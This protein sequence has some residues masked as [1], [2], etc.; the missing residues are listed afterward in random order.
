MT[1]VFAQKTFPLWDAPVDFCFTLRGKRLF[2]SHKTWRGMLAGVA[3]ATATYLVQR[4]LLV[5]NAAVRD[6]SAFDYS[7]HSIVLGAWIGL[8]GLT[9]DLIKS[10]VKRQLDI[11]PGRPWIPFDQADWLIETVSVSC[12]VVQ[13]PFAFSLTVLVVGIALHI[14]VNIVAHLLGLRRTWS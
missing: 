13:L 2:G 4:S 6:I 5:S 7:Q 10:A 14:V 1:A 11:C 9:G 12:A 3:A 8:G